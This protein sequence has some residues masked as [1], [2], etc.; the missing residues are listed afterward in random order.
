MGKTKKS[1]IEEIKKHYSSY[2]QTYLEVV[3]SAIQSHRSAD[4][5]IMLDY[6]FET[7]KIKSGQKLLDAGCGVCGP[8]IHFAKKADIAIE[9]LNIS[10]TQ[11]EIAKDKIRA[12]GLENKIN[13]V[14]GDY[15]SLKNH[16][17]KNT[18]DIVYFL[19]SYGHCLNHKQLLE[20]AM[21]VLK[22]G[23]ILY[24]KDY[25]KKDLAEMKRVSKIAKLMNKKYAYNLPCLY[26][27]LSI[28]RKQNM[29]IIN[30]GK[31]KFDDDGGQL[32]AEF[33]R[34]S[35]LCLFR[36]GEEMFSYADIFEIIARKPIT[37][38]VK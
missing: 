4:E 12:S 15:H 36:E 17:Q 18:F 8:A 27:T 5:E 3:D 38:D 19:E 21:F 26:S 22:Y 32:S 11:I 37:S 29:D 33:S 28:L 34:K 25:F 20:S 35:N 10:D 7:M 14:Y 13:A 23:G 24:I 6:Y 2:T 30:I 1:K 31:P 16:Y 9:A